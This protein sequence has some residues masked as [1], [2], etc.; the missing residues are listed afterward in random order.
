MAPQPINKKDQGRI[1]LNGGSS[2]NCCLLEDSLAPASGFACELLQGLSKRVHG[3][4]VSQYSSR[5][6]EVR[7]VRA[8]SDSKDVKDEDLVP[9]YVGLRRFY[10]ELVFCHPLNLIFL[11]CAAATRSV[12]ANGHI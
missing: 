6:S 1:S 11:F 4:C 8:R 5:N 10:L 2:T 3:L 12:R 9:D 7:A